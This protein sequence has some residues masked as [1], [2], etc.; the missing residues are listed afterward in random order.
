MAPNLYV[1]HFLKNLKPPIKSSKKSKTKILDVDNNRIY[2]C[3]K[4]QSQTHCIF[5]LEKKT[6]V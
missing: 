5:G 1:A 4:N 2:C 3:A 6:N